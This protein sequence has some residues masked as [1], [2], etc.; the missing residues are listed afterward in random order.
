MMSKR[1]NSI[2]VIFRS[3]Y[4]ID[5]YFIDNWNPVNTEAAPGAIM[6]NWDVRYDNIRKY[7]SEILTFCNICTPFPEEA[8]E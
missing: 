1:R 6:I 5:T 2:T 7:N 8:Y 3:E 4:Y